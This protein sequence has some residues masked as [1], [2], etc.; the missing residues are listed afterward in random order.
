VLHA[1]LGYAVRRK[2]LEKN[3]V[4]KANLPEGWTPP[5]APEVA[6]DPRCVGSPALIAS[7]LAYCSY[8]GRRQG[9]RF[10]AFVA[11]MYYAMMRPSEV[12]ALTSAGC[13]S[14]VRDGAT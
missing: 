1:V 3:P 9:P 6:I 7:M 12:A 14:R 5:P 2:R 11:C 4:S 13:H 10:A 8:V